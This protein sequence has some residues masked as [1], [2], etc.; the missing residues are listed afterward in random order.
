LPVDC[1]KRLEDG[2]LQR[3]LNYHN[4]ANTPKP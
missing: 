4:R 2:T 1:P 3:L